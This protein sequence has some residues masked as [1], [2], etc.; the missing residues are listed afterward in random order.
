MVAALAGCAS[1]PKKDAPLV[2]SL[3]IQGASAV[4]A[5]TIK[6]KI[7]TTATSRLPFASKLLA[8]TKTSGTDAQMTNL[9][10]AA[11]PA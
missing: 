11:A 7:L 5:R 3:T 9:D 8:K 10:I 4:S 6:D 1:T 2:H